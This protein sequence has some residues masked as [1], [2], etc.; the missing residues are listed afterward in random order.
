MSWG[1]VSLLVCFCAE[2]LSLLIA[3]KLSKIK[4]IQRPLALVG[5]VI[6]LPA[7]YIITQVSLFWENLL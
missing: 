1:I 2:L 6:V 3:K 7:Q 4:Q 5:V